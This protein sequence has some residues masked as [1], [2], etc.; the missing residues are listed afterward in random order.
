M[1][2]CRCCGQP[3]PD[4]ESITNLGGEID[5]SCYTWAKDFKV[6]MRRYVPDGEIW[7]VE[8]SKNRIHKIINCKLE[9][10]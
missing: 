6:F 5:D 8:H 4:I 7:I 10:E 1:D 3:I 9:G 2:K